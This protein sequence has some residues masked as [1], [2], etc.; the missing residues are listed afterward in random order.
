MRCCFC[1]GRPHSVNVNVKFRTTCFHVVRFGEDVS[2]RPRP[3]CR[4][5]TRSR[6][7]I[8]PSQCLKSRARAP[9]G[10]PQIESPAFVALEIQRSPPDIWRPRNPK[11]RV[12]QRIKNLNKPEGHTCRTP[13]AGSPTASKARNTG[14]RQTKTHIR[15]NREGELAQKSH[16]IVHLSV[17]RAPRH[18]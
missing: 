10:C 8:T 6:Y 3:A 12:A 14:E 17:G 15:P 5:S 11:S 4:S 1:V 13:R 18:R 7:E 2:F 16:E 9:S